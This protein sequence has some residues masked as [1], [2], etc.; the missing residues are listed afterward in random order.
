MLQV[1]ALA[2]LGNATDMDLI[3]L[4]TMTKWQADKVANCQNDLAP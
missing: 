2:A 1:L 3:I 4:V